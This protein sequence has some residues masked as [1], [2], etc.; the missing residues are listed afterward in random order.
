MQ[1]QLTIFRRGNGEYRYQ[2]RGK[3]IRLN[4]DFTIS[5]GLKPNSKE[6]LEAIRD[7]LKADAGHADAAFA[8]LEV[9]D[10]E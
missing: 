9:I 1:K 6:E 2:L 5:P 4:G 7:K 10:D 8:N 3:N